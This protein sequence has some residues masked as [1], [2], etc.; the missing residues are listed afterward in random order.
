MAASQLTYVV[1]SDATNS[2]SLA[3]AGLG[4]IG[5]R[6]EPM[7]AW[8]GWA[9]LGNKTK[10]ALIGGF[11][12]YMKVRVD[13]HST[14]RPHQHSVVITKDSTGMMGGAM[15]MSKTKKKFDEVDRAVVARFGPA[16]VHRQAL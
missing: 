4:Y 10:A 5:F 9:E 13:V 15:G 6:Y 7:T 12:L 2:L 1:A 8:S 16:L 3:V 11:S 14:E